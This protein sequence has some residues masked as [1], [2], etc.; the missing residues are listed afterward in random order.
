MV[1]RFCF[2]SSTNF[3][4]VGVWMSQEFGRT[5]FCKALRLAGFER[6]STAPTFFKPWGARVSPVLPVHRT[7]CRSTMMPCFL[8]MSIVCFSRHYA[9]VCALRLV[10]SIQMPKGVRSVERSR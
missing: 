5:P 9:K 10:G 1:W 4:V 2:P 3:L 8:R 6:Q 7:H